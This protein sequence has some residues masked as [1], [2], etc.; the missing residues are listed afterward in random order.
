MAGVR[1]LIFLGYSFLV[2]RVMVFLLFSPLCHYRWGH[3]PA[4]AKNWIF[5][6]F[7]LEAPLKLLAGDI[8]GCYVKETDQ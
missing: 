3:H 8:L 2:L 1:S 5:S 7:P 6:S 4:L